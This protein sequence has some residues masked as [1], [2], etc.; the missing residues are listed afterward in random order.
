MSRIRVRDWGTGTIRVRGTAK[1][2]NTR[3]GYDKKII[4]NIKLYY[5]KQSPKIY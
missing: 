4:L 5:I 3:Y 1:F 2:K